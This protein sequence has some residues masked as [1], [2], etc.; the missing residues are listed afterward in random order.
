MWNAFM[1]KRGL[2]DA[3]TQRLNERL[4]GLGLPPDTVQ[5]MFDSPLLDNGVE[6]GN[7]RGT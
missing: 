4:T 3:G 7:N 2:R 1:T 5:T 6:R